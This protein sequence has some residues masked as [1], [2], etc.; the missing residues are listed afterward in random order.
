MYLWNLLFLLLL[1]TSRRTEAWSPST[2]RRRGSIGITWASP[3]SPRTLGTVLAADA[4]TKEAIATAIEE[5]DDG[6]AKSAFGTKSYWDDVY[7]GQGDFPADE[8]SW[9]YGWDVLSKLLQPYLPP[10]SAGPRILVPGIG[11]DPLLTDLLAAGYTYLTAQDY[12][13]SALDRQRDLLDY[14]YF[15][16]NVD[17]EEPDVQLCESNVRQLPAVWSK[18]F[19]VILEKGLLDAVYLSG[20][21]DTPIKEAVESLTAV[22][23]PGA[24]LVSV[25]GVVPA[26]LRR[27][28][29]FSRARWKWLRDGSHDLQ[30]GCFVLQRK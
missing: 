12:S 2:R 30:A 21:N 15:R 13:A 18:Q 25:S 9:Y 24:L 26:D 8:Y 17:E 27:D 11:N 7:Q 3:Q 6:D 16:S 22:L 1:A 10:P 23:K 20:S 19:D 14:Y 5:D 4:A 28:C 29:L